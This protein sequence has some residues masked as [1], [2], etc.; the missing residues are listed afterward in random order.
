MPRDRDLVTGT[1]AAI[2]AA[3]LF[4]MLGPLARFAAQAG[5]EG[6]A[7]T[8]WRATLGVTFLVVLIVAGGASGHRPPRSSASTGAAGR[9]CSPPR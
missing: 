5:V 9:P 2:I 1:L 3:T 4:G 7:F 8:S 6:V